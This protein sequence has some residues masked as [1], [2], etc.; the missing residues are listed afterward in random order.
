MVSAMA[1]CFRLA[2][3]LLTLMLGACAD[4]LNWNPDMHQVVAGDT[5][6]SISFR[7]RIDQRDLIR[8]NRLGA[9]GFIYVGQQLRLTPPEGYRPPNTSGGQGRPPSGQSSPP[10]AATKPVMGRPY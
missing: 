4:A 9:D 5:V 7:Y 10:V 6:Y 3:V 1:K 2:P 8:W